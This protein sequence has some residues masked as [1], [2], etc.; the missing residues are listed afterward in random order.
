[1]PKVGKKKGAYALQSSFHEV[2]CHLNEL[3]LAGD[4]TRLRQD[5]DKVVVPQALTL[6]GYKKELSVQPQQDITKEELN[7]LSKE[8]QQK[9]FHTYVS[10]WRPEPDT[11]TRGRLKARAELLRTA[12][13]RLLSQAKAQ[14]AEIDAIADRYLSF[15]STV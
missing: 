6:L 2:R 4:P 7:F 15:K 1:M 5:F 9:F 11:A 10:Y 14:I 12:R 13:T 3:T 8:E